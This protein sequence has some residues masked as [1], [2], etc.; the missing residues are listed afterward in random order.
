MLVDAS[1]A[2]RAG[3]DLENLVSEALT[4][5]GAIET[6]ARRVGHKGAVEAA[7]LAGGFCDG[8]TPRARAVVCLG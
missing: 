3:A 4:A 5:Q 2:S 1:G 7:F 6:L 8:R